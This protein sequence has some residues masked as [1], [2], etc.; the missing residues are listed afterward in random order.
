MLASVVFAVLAA[1]RAEFDIDMP[2]L[3]STSFALLSGGAA[4]IIATWIAFAI[5][6][7][8]LCG[9]SSNFSTS[10]SFSYIVLGQFANTVLPFRLGDVLRLTLFSKKF[11]LN[12]G[13]TAAA[14]ILEKL[15]DLVLLLLIGL[16][17]SWFTDVGDNIRRAVSALAAPALMAIAVLVIIER[18]S[19]AREKFLSALS[20][21]LPEKLHQLATSAIE[22]FALGVSHVSNA[23]Q[24]VNIILM[25]LVGWFFILM[26]IWLILSAYIEHCKPLTALLYVVLTNL[27][28]AIPSAPASVG[29]YE[30]LAVVALSG[31]TPSQSFALGVAVSTHGLVVLVTAVLGSIIAALEGVSLFGAMRESQ[32]VE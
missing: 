3:D 17:A 5:R 13:S 6:W 19:G 31:V 18:W 4:L 27:G 23:R 16:A 22:K 12:M 32:K 20:K 9:P 8:I 11:N 15:T 25:S 1:Q 29:V 26:S 2:A 24:L 21:I 28:G 7:K 10:D 30:Y 14:L